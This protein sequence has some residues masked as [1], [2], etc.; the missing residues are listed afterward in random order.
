MAT[1]WVA[2]FYLIGGEFGEVPRT[3]VRGLCLTGNLITEIDCVY[4]R[5]LALV[6]LPIKGRPC[7]IEQGGVSWFTE[8]WFLSQR[9]LESCFSACSEHIHSYFLLSCYIPCNE[10]SVDFSKGGKGWS[11]EPESAVTRQKTM[12]WSCFDFFFHIWTLKLTTSWLFLLNQD[13][14]FFF[15]SIKISWSYMASERSCCRAL[16]RATVSWFSIH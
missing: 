1:W 9:N 4:I 5:I 10:K 15:C 7:L 11:E 16:C 2:S 12:L 13:Y 6:F 14:R 3:E 8:N